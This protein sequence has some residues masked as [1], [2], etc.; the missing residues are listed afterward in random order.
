MWFGGPKGRVSG[1]L[2]KRVSRNNKVRVAMERRKFLSC[3]IA[4]LAFTTVSA[5]AFAEGDDD[6]AG[7]TVL[8]MRTMAPAGSLWAK[9]FKEWKET[10]K[11]KSGKKLVLKWTWNGGGRDEKAMVND[12]KSGTLDG[13]AMTSVGLSSFVKDMLIFNLPGL[14]DSWDDLDKVRVNE[15]GY[16]QKE[17]E[18]QDMILAGT[19]DVGK[20]RLMGT[21][22]RWNDEVWRPANLQNK[23]LACVEADVIGPKLLEIQ[24]ASCTPVGINEIGSKLGTSITVLNTPSYAA[25]QLGW[26]KKVRFVLKGLVP[27]YSIGGIVFSKK[28]VDGLSDELKTALLDSAKERGQALTKAVRAADNSAYDQI[29]RKCEERVKKEENKGTDGGPT[30]G[31]YDIAA[32]KDDDDDTK[33]R[34]AEIRGQWADLFKKTREALRGEFSSDMYD[35]VVTGRGK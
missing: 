22:D 30:T 35:R 6:E 32:R 9:Q 8:K 7:A 19:G 17:F 28:A 1:D 14:F 16:F 24:G 21:S 4:T 15:M 13:A 10:L 12:L 3:L 2:K 18:K 33:S 26:S 5:T 27:Y 11:D 31:T 25:L 34:K 29:A 20:G 23:A